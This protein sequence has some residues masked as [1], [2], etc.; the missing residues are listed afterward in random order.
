M[1][2]L[3]FC[4]N[5]GLLVW[6]VGWALCSIPALAQAKTPAIKPAATG[7]V[8]SQPF[9]RL[10]TG[11]HTAAIWR[12]A[13]DA[14]EHYLVT[15]S[16]DK[17]ARVWELA[18]GKLLQTLR[19]P[20]GEG[21][22]G[23]VYAVA[24][25]P[26][27]GTVAVGGWTQA[28]EPGDSIYLFQ[29]ATGKLLLRLNGLPNV[30]IDLRFSPDGRLLA[31]ALGGANGIRVY[32]TD[33]WNAA[34][35]D[36]DY[37]GD[38]YSVD[39]DPK[40]RLVT[41]CE[42][43]YIRLYDA[44]FHL[45]AKQT[46]AGGKQPFF[47][48]F[49]PTGEKIAVGFDDSTAVNVLS[50]VDLHLL[51][52][53]DTALA[54]NGNL[55]SVAW[56][57]DGLQLYAGG[58]Y[59]EKSGWRPV[60]RWQEAG[61]G[62]KQ[63]FRVS[64]NTIRDLR[65]LAN[66][67]L[68]FGAA[69]PLFG[70]LQADGSKRWEKR[71]ETLDF[72]DQ[73]N[74]LR[75]SDDGS[76]VEFAFQILGPEKTT[77][78]TARFNLASQQLQFDPPPQSGLTAPHTEGESHANW[79]NTTTA[80]VHGVALTLKPY[81]MSRSLALAANGTGFLLGTEWWLRYYD[82]PKQQRWPTAIPGI[83]WAVNLSA[84]GRYA[85]AAFADGTIRWYN[86]SDGKEVL[87]LYVNPDE[88]R[89]IA[90]TP[91]GFYAAAPG[92]EGLVGYHLNQG[93][94]HAGEFVA[95]KQLQDGFYRPD[96]ITHRLQANGDALLAE[97]VA[98]LGDVRSVLAGGLPPKLHLLSPAQAE[99]TGDYAIK[100]KVQDQGGGVARIVY[101]IDGVERHSRP[102]DIPGPDD[103]SDTIALDSGRH[104]ITAVALNREGVKSNE[105]QAVVEVKAP[106]V[107]ADL[108]VLAVG[109]TAYDDHGFAEGV[110]FAAQDAE[111]IRAR[112]DIANSRG[113]YKHIHLATLL[114]RQATRANILAA[115]GMLGNAVKPSDVFVLYLSG[116]GTAIDGA[117]H[118]VPQ[119]VRYTNRE[120]LHEQ[121]LDETSLRTA[122]SGIKAGKSLILIDTCSSGAFAGPPGRYLGEKE[123]LDRFS[124][125]TGRTII[126][127]A[128]NDKMALE[129]EGGHGAF[130]YILLEALKGKAAHNDSGFILVSELAA[131][132]EEE[133]PRLTQR[134]W[135]YQQIPVSRMEGSFPVLPKETP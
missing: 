124:R 61:R 30:I 94:D 20:L 93:P 130:T 49:D 101:K 111:S 18:T 23:K 63:S 108:Y 78:R 95:A 54:K 70:V 52:A 104:V 38:S 45:L 53:P 107:K 72:R 65:P 134:K 132:V 91:E 90:W 80:K 57:Q 89:W 16:D 73:E 37:Q 117:Y 122:L 86:T 8:S 120:R 118:F 46:A 12:I 33:N 100:L 121:S 88:H 14:A 66:G 115:L 25:S 74:R 6:L 11:G 69:D 31:A 28:G 60:L 96:L 42:D 128:A 133:L 21:D 84:D 71:G 109:V 99:S 47:A 64:P 15:G 81:E 129:G 82:S 110:R 58:F 35:R 5:V 10:E 48:R 68:A 32:R 62:A 131:Y 26:D 2:L 44:S 19:P 87:A 116:H 51:Y 9:L 113:L 135:G 1:R 125:V 39:F 59:S 41:T 97:A 126:A 24:I 3:R 4:L 123:A 114:D 106:E 34:A 103:Y 43:S 92:A 85:V 83:A 112:F 75:V 17:T 50:G 55:E 105:V 119:E 7:A 77:I 102:A 29:R 27:G 98:K 13:V 76:V 22:E 36:T 79:K 56:S 127:A 67:R 40:G